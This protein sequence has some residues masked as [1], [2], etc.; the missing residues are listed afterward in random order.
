[1][2]RRGT[3]DQ[4]EQKVQNVYM[5]HFQTDFERKDCIICR[6][7]K[8]KKITKKFQKNIFLL[9]PTFRNHHFQLTCYIHQDFEAGARN[10]HT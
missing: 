5:V 1:M 9:P 4:E 10:D 3:V 7:L 8:K 2:Q 6:M